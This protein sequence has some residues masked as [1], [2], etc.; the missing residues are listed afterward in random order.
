MKS[1]L[2]ILQVVVVT[3]EGGVSNTIDRFSVETKA[4]CLK[5]E[6]IMRESFNWQKQARNDK[7][8]IQKTRAYSLAKAKCIPMRGVKWG[9]GDE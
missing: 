6:K 7:G 4:V 9:W 8:L 5:V 3:P 2:L 1:Y